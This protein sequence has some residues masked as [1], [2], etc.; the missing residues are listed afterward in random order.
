MSTLLINLRLDDILRKLL[1][2]LF[3][4]RAKKLGCSYSHD[5]DCQFRLRTL[6]IDFGVL[7]CG[8]IGFENAPKAAGLFDAFDPV[9]EGFGFDHV[10]VVTFLFHEHFPEFAFVA[11]DEH[12]WD[13]GDPE[14][15]EML[16]KKHFMVFSFHHGD[17]IYDCWIDNDDEIL[18]QHQTPSIRYCADTLLGLHRLLSS[19]PNP[20]NNISQ[21]LS[22]N[23]RS[24]YNPATAYA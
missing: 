6:L 21:K 15:G 13:M 8:S 19:N 18:T 14:E 23:T 20:L 3:D 12:F 16:E 4:R 7:K 5:G 22:F 10:G 9:I 2:T 17:L 1:R 24:R 11:L